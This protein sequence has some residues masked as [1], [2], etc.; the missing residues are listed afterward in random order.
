MINLALR[1]EFSFRKCYGHLDKLVHDSDIAVGIADTDN[2]FGHV[3]LQSAC[4]EAGIKPIFGVRLMVT[5]ERK[6]KEKAWGSESVFL[7]KNVDGLREIYK[8][9]SLAYQNFYYHPYVT[10]GNVLNTISRNVIVI[11]HVINSRTNYLALTH[12]TP[13]SAFDQA[14]DRKI[15]PVLINYNHY[16]T[17][18]D[19]AVYD[20][21]V[22]HRFRDTQTYPQHILDEGELQFELRDRVTNDL[23]FKHARDNTYVISDMCQHFELP[24]ASNIHYEGK[25]TLEGL[26]LAG[27]MRRGIDLEDEIYGARLDRELKLIHEKKYA[28][29][30][31]IVYEMVNEAKKVMLVGPS[32]G[33]SAGSLVSYL[34]GITEVD[35]IKYDLLFE[36][37][38]DINRLDLPDIDIDFPDWKRK[39][40]I[41][42]LVRIYGNKNVAHL[43]I[44]ARGK[45]KSVLRDFAASLGVPEFEIEATKDAIIDRSGGDAR[46]SMRTRDT[47]EN[48]EPGKELVE[49]YPQM[50]LACEAEEHAHHFG[51]HAA[52]MIV[53]NEPLTHY[54]SINARNEAVQ[55]CGDDA[56]KLNLLK[57]D[58]L[59]LRTLS[60]LEEFCTLIDFDFHD[61]Y[62]IDLEMPKVLEIFKQ[63][64]LAG[65]FQFE[66]YAL[67][68]LTQDLEV[69][70]FDDIVVLTS[71]GRPGPIHSGGAADYV[72]KHNGEKEITYIS[73]HPTVLKWTKDTLGTILFQEQ[74]MGI[75]RDFG[76]LSWNDVSELRKA[77][78]KSKGQEFFNRYWERFVKGT[79]E[80]HISDEEAEHVWKNMMTFG[81]W[82][83]NKSHAVAYAMI[84]YW[85]AW[86]KAQDP[87]NFAVACM[88]HTSD[89]WT[90]IRLLREMVEFDGLEYE[91]VDPDNSSEGWSVCDG[92][93][94]GGLTNIH[95]VGSQK[96]KQILRARI[97]KDK[98][99]PGLIK[100]LLKPE[101]DF[102][103]LFPCQHYFGHF[104]DNPK[105]H[106]LDVSPTLIRDVDGKGDWI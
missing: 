69:K 54:T 55:L 79:R 64:R 35:P 47:L 3:R 43:G 52:G 27:A 4:Q 56:E 89:S 13:N 58:C 5:S 50:M 77:L 37:F 94:I 30:F 33:S 93:L 57:I 23:Y 10:L 20:L 76:G 21:L 18:E 8:L 53:C 46:A 26:C 80:K 83:F 36:R 98:L 6:D 41:D 51:V 66:G 61:L 60:I 92:K 22:G 25:H 31:L 17:L 86:A 65:I 68:W 81:S 14:S 74:V 48:T 75:A 38:I 24:V 34:I 7:A 85:T 16:P 2:T 42:R 19:K 15:P 63:C 101:T 12:S 104:F 71:L 105:E 96:A 97:G 72:K 70:K 39:R 40:V 29:Y 67:R 102:D 91:P 49:K 28:D 99:G 78:G 1:S 100:K 45:P 87:L 32:R 95:G 11:S 73:K 62:T 82:G 9:V 106:G 103:V 59:G 90:A 44:V 88:N 84:S